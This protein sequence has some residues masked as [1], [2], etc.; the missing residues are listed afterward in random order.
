M[1]KTLIWVGLGGGIGSILRYLAGL[2][3]YRN[4][5]TAFP[6]GTFVVNVLGGFL[7]GL[8]TAVFTRGLWPE[9]DIRLFLITGLCGGFTTFS[10]FSMEN[11]K[12]IQEHQFVLASCYM[13]ASL[14]V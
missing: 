8:L 5:P 14:F 9:S 7:I 13:M 6:L 3:I 12:L 10:A 2:W 1:I 4:F 11:L